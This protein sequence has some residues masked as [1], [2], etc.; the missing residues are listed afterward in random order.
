VANAGTSAN[1]A[2]ASALTFETNLLGAGQTTTDGAQR[3][4]KGVLIGA[5]AAGLLLAAAGGTWF[6]RNQSR[7]GQTPVSGALV[8]S[9]AVVQPPTQA[10]APTANGSQANPVVS[11]VAAAPIP[12]PT[13]AATGTGGMGVNTST[14]NTGNPAVSNAVVKTSQPAP[15]KASAPVQIQPQPKK[16][17]LGKVRLAAPTLNRSGQARSGD[18][19]EPGISLGNSEPA[20]D[21]LGSGLESN[22]KGPVAPSEPLPVG[23]DVKPAKLLVSVSPTYPSLA[24]SQHVSGDVKVDA[25]IDANGKVTT[26]KIVSGPTLLHQSAMDA[27]RQWKYQPATLDGKTVPM[28]LTVTLQFRLQ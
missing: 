1:D 25:L 22:S 17:A 24:K 7:T 18:E 9:A 8:S 6:V 15:E 2:D 10:S 3:S 20:P 4:N 19:A 27:L 28:H 21:S 13:N 5:I 23:G 26:M 12:S 16:T 11:A 14:G